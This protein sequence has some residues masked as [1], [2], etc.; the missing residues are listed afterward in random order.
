MKLFLFLFFIFSFY[1]LNTFAFDEEMILP[2]LDN[3]HNLI[4]K[5][6][7][8]QALELAQDIKGSEKQMALVNY[9]LGLSSNRLAKFSEASQYFKKAI[10]LKSSRI[11]IFY[12]YGQSLYAMNEL[13]NARSQFF[14]SYKSNF[15]KGQ[16]LYYMGYIS[17][18]LEQYK[19]SRSFYLKI[20]L[21]PDLYEDIVSPGYMQLGEIYLSMYKNHKS[22]LKVVQKRVLPM[23]K[24]SIRYAVD[25]KMKKEIEKRLVEVKRYYGLDPNVLY[26]GKVLPDKKNIFSLSVGYNSN[27]N[28]T[29]SSSPQSEDTTE[30][31][32]NSFFMQTRLIL[33]RK[34]V[35]YPQLTTNLNYHTNRDNSSINSYDGYSVTP[36]LKMRY[37][38]KI[39]SKLSAFLI[40]GSYFRS[41]RDINSASSYEQD[42]TN[43]TFTTGEEISLSNATVNIKLKYKILNNVDDSYGGSGIGVSLGYTRAL[44]S[45]SFLIANLNADFLSYEDEDNNLDS[46]G[47]TVTYMKPKLYNIVTLLA[48]SSLI[49]TDPVASRESRGLEF[50]YGP[51]IKIFK[52]FGK[53]TLSINYNYTSKSSKDEDNYSYSKSIYGMTLQYL[54]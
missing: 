41:A 9:Y 50:S 24:K 44:K 19:K 3:I 5:K 26:N 31:Y 49:L 28:Y 32:T 10:D 29:E 23:F 38:H 34:F 39:G 22:I 2:T 42:S 40:D 12:E 47:L 36:A 15:N 33:N 21:S 7:F 48:G 6:D 25:E 43:F 17:Q 4:L 45:Q 8:K 37:E 54:F 14:K 35:F 18:I 53:Y 20:L 27:N 51:Y 11:D 13:E 52:T 1:P 46:Y 16:S 30:I